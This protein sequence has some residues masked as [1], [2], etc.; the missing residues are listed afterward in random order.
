MIIYLVC[1]KAEA[2]VS[3][4]GGYV[5][6]QFMMMVVNVNVVVYVHTCNELYMD[7]V[8]RIK[9]RMKTGCNNI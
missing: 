3:N 9:C 2:V 1:A 6:K 8:K 7:N 4:V 5:S